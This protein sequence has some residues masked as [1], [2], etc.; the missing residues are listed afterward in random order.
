MR[1]PL[2]L[3]PLLGLSVGCADHWQA[4]TWVESDF[5]FEGDAC[6]WASN[7]VE[8]EEPHRYTLGDSTADYQ[9]DDVDLYDPDQRFSEVMSWIANKGDNVWEI[10]E[11][12]NAMPKNS[13]QMYCPVAIQLMQSDLGLEETLS[14]RCDD[15]EDP[16]FS[17]STEAMLVNEGEALVSSHI[18][19]YCEGDQSAWFDT[20]G[21][22]SGDEE[23]DEEDDEESFQRCDMH[24]TSWL[25]KE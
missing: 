22:Y 12:Y 17:S 14:G 3:W 18:Q 5:A 19:S 20:G 21:Y 11:P 23:D 24:Y 16:F 7:I 25:R 8:P 10:C 4:G 2:P 15:G 9:N 6:S 1:K 13:I